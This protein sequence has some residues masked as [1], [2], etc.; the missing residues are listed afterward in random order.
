MSRLCRN[1]IAN[2]LNR[3]ISQRIPIS[4][5]NSSARGLSKV[6]ISTIQ[7]LYVIA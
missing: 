1:A 4:G 5:I 3:A 7:V 6:S 2:L